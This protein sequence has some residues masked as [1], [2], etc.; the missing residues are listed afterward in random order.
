MT[1]LLHDGSETE[2]QLIRIWRD[3]HEAIR[4]LEGL[5]VFESDIELRDNYRYLPKNGQDSEKYHAISHDGA[6]KLLDRLR[7]M[8]FE[9][10]KKEK[11]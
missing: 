9:V 10:R 3:A 11:A 6:V 7:F 2:A 1:S 8:G 5:C 4:A